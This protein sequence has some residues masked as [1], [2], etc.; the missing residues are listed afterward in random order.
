MP[1]V[2][3]SN[4]PTFKKLA[5]ESCD[6][7]T[8]EDAARF[9][10]APELHIG[11]LNLMPDA[12][13]EA[14]ERQFIRLVTAFDQSARLYVHPFTFAEK[15]RCEAAREHIATYYENFYEL[16]QTGL[17]AMIVTGANPAT[18][19]ITRETFWQPMMEAIEW[20]RGNV[21]SI[22]CSCLATH[23]VLKFYHGIER[24]RLPQKRWGVYSHRLSAPGHPLLK[25]VTS[26]CDG[27]HSHVFDVSHEQMEKAGCEILAVSDEA[28]VYLAVG[29]DPCDFVFFQGHPE[30]D[31][32]S[33]LKELKRE[34]MRY[35][36]DERSDYPTFPAHY[37]PTEAINVLDAF[38]QELVDAKRENISLP[39]FPEEAVA[40]LVADTW[41]ES[42]RMF[43]R[44]WLNTLRPRP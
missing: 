30:Y 25:D 33:L 42:G 2:A 41:R 36:V 34:V 27:P 44:N 35:T 32:V 10:G 21:Q 8:P 17:D 28:G 16:Q 19:D 4:L 38:R 1:L 12:A 9:P 23:A 31:A 26:P 14:T 43:Y 37:L 29:S 3:H 18:S 39:D 20:G 24:V 11:F 22:L 13:L 15:H 5:E 7:V 40:P 6:V